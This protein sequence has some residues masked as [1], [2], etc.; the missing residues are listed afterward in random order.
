MNCEDHDEVDDE[1]KLRLTAWMMTSLTILKN[2]GC[3]G[4]IVVP[5][6]DVLRL[7]M[8]HWVLEQLHTTLVVAENTNH[9]QLEIKQS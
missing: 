3:P 5:D 2:F 4:D 1:A 7:V 9:L 6:L 8:K